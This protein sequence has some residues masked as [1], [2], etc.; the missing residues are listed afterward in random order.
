MPGLGRRFAG[1]CRHAQYIMCG[2]L[3][4]STATLA[5]CAHWDGAGPSSGWLLPNGERTPSDDHGIST[6]RAFGSRYKAAHLATD[7]G[8]TCLREVLW[9]LAIEPST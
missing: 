8:M 4:D 1:R 5:A 2:T 3:M 6:K 9:P 7:P